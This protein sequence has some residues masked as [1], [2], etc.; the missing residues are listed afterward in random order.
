MR[1]IYLVPVALMLAGCG[2]VPGGAKYVRADGRPV[3]QAQIDADLSSCASFADTGQRCMVA[4]GYFAVDAD[5]AE[6]KQAELAQIAAANQ[7]REAARLEA[8]RKQQE[9]AER[10]RRREAAKRKKK[11]PA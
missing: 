10:A 3:A 6:Q 5:K 7:Q 2:G 9:A 8:E 11:P 1:A 4:K